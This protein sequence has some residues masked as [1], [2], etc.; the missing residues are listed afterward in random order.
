MVSA[1]SSAVAMPVPWL[2]LKVP[3]PLVVLGVALLM[4][5]AALAVPGL[6]WH[7]AAGTVCAV[8]LAALGLGIAVA[9]VVSF[10][11]AHTTVNPLKPS[12][13]SSL[14]DRHPAPAGRVPAADDGGP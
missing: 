8:V 6:A 14:V 9:G 4:W 7:M 13:A 3:P 2:E 1:A 10:A 11:R 12:A 5:L